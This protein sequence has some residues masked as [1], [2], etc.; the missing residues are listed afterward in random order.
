MGV[1]HILKVQTHELLNNANIPQ[2]LDDNRNKALRSGAIVK[3][4]IKEGD[5]ETAKAI[6]ICTLENIIYDLKPLTGNGKKTANQLR[7]IL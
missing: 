2:S 1:K 3:D 6:L 4:A 5:M 7:R